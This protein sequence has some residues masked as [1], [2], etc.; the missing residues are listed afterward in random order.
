MPA[1]VPEIPAKVNQV[2]QVDRHRLRTW[3]RNLHRTG[4]PNAKQLEQWQ[5]HADK[6]AAL[7]LLR[8]DRVPSINYPAS[9][10]VTSHRDEL[11]R[12]LNTRQTIVV[13]GETGSG[14]STQLPK[15]CLE[16]GF[17]AR[18]IIGHTQPRRLAA[19]AV[20]ARLAE[21]LSTSVGDL[22]GFKIRFSDTTNP[23]TLV[24][25]MT[26][27]VLLAETQ[28]DRFLDQYEV[29]IIDEAHE[30]SLNIDF[31]LGYVRQ[32][33]G[34]RPDLK[35]IIT[36][37]TID[38]ERFSNH[39]QDEQ[40]PAPIVEVSGRTYPVEIRYQPPQ[41]LDDLGQPDETAQLSA[42]ADAV[43]SLLIESHGDILVFL[44][45]ERDIRISAKHLRGHL[46]RGGWQQLE[47]LPLYARLSQAEQNKIFQQSNSR[48]IVLATNV[49]ESSLTVPGIH[50]VVDTG[51]ARI[52]R[53][54]PRSKVRRLPIENISQASANQRSGRCGRLGP[55]ICIRLYAR[56]D[57]E[58]RS[59]FTTP[60]IRRSD[61]ASVLLQ[62]KIL[63][64]GSLDSFP[65]LDP[66]TPESL[67]D[68]ERTL[69]ELTAIDDRGQLTKI[70]QQLGKLPVEPRV[71]RL[72]IE[73]HDRNC[74]SEIIVIAGA[75]ETQDVRLRPAGQQAEADQA[76][77]QFKD[78]H[79][80]FL[81]FIR[82][83]EFHERL[84]AD[85]G[86]SRLQKALSQKFLSFQAY[87]EWHDTVRQLREILAEIG[88]RSSTKVL[89]L[90]PIEKVNQ[91][92]A[93][94]RS[95]RER[96]QPAAKPIPR[97]PGYEPI[98]QALLSGML[99]GLAYWKDRQEY[100][101]AGGM[102]VYLWPGSGLFQR[103]PK[104]IM[105]AEFVETSKR[106]A[107]TVAEIDPLWVERVAEK[108]LK[109]SYQDPHW[110]SKTG[111]AMVYQKSTLYGLPVV[112]GR[113][114]PLSP[115]DQPLARQL[116]I[117][118]GLVAGEWNCREKF[119]LHNQELLADM[120]ELMQRT[121]HRDFIV[122][123]FHLQ[124][125]YESRLPQAVTDLNS[126]K[127]WLR[128]AT[129]QERE[130]LLLRAEDLVEDDHPELLSVED[131]YPN[132]FQVAGTRLP[133]TYHFEPGHVQDGVTVTVPQTA[134]RQIGKE[135]LGWVVPGLLEEKVLYLIR[136]LPKHLRTSF[137]P[138][139]D[140]ARKLANQLLEKSRDQPFYET[141]CQLMSE[142]S[143][144]R[145]RQGDFDEGKLP[146]HLRFNVR[147]IDPGGRELAVSRDVVALQKE[148]S[149]PDM[150]DREAQQLAADVAW[151]NRVVTL[152]DLAQ[153]PRQVLIRRA[154]I[155]IAAFPTLFQVGRHVEA[156]LTDSK[157]DAEQR[158]PIGLCQLFCDKYQRSLR[159]QVSHLPQVEK[160]AVKLTHLLAGKDIHDELMRLIARLAFIES[161]TDFRDAVTME[162]TL[163]RSTQDIS[164]AT[165]EVASW[166]PRMAEQ[167]F[168]L[169]LALEKMPAMWQEVTEDVQAQVTA[170]VSNDFLQTVPWEWLAEYPRYFQAM[171]IRIGKLKTG[172][173]P[174]D[175]SSRQEL[176]AIRQRW[177]DLNSSPGSDLAKAEK[178][179]NAKW[180]I[181]E[182][183]VS[184][185]AQQ[186]GT[187]VAVSA[188]RIRA[189]LE[190]I[191]TL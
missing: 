51:L 5:S 73:G 149:L 88:L 136:S 162:A 140:V 49:A 110:S 55:G 60:E 43:D 28:N 29:L 171:Q 4:Q 189:Q 166:L 122:D 112:V 167:A 188:K 133:L 25:V 129:D 52:S 11:L 177:Q 32:L 147:V 117:E 111:A 148:L 105:A 65:L 164:V 145:I 158:W 106:Y 141:L 53:Y 80:D 42:I 121:R 12:L 142:F 85:L 173:L 24:K 168:Q 81:S 27:G 102:A 76:H 39:F 144:Q 18:G 98:H 9:L 37:A 91:P 30:R 66:P 47:I 36:S 46:T 95:G 107:R 22:V 118:H 137:V 82:L 69:K 3:W 157:L 26:D 31:L 58:S 71:G 160:A 100:Q 152:H 87:R 61:L 10:P 161:G 59:A 75:L 45:T 50:S 72:L 103:R 1:R 67:R 150:A 94:E 15:I 119:Y 146:D 64:L 79:S 33:Q 125:F 44:P 92:E 138:A 159:S 84:R 90:A 57:Y 96:G 13:C 132:E 62:S 77:A 163:L 108:L 180:L 154:G 6:S 182:W 104:W 74:L 169:R 174:K 89:Q 38:P 21:E 93:T 116:M 179:N 135:V 187:K 186:L 126:L 155:Q 99:S 178:L 130:T 83:W 114:V 8:Q 165:Q 134:L 35:L 190:E 48:R 185:F 127:L 153:L 63:K 17:G 183:S 23:Q 181:E 20:A 14:K 56:T 40:G 184:I 124:N 176:T 78:P 131:S 109:H 170:L 41:E 123:R 97:P 19:R 68:A 34:R 156:R 86:R 143:G 139:P 101:A 7:C 172:G 2:M 115:I 113:R 16:A 191:D 120:H 54:A 151:E 128:K 70:G 175:R